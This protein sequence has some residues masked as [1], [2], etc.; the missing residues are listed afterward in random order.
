LVVY[1]APTNPSSEE[2]RME[3]RD[4]ELVDRLAL[5]ALVDEY[6]LAVDARDPDRFAGLFTP[7]GVL[8]V[9]EPDDPEPSLTYS[10]T[11]ELRTVIDLLAPFTST[12][13][14]MANHTATIDAP[15]ARTTTYCLAHHLTEAEGKDPRDTLM[16]IR[17]DDTLRKSPAGWR[18]TRRDV[19]RQWTEYHPAER[20]RLAG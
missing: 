2:P 4:D 13:H 11:D 15:A 6:A 3:I 19:L 10:G 7:D 8:A 12:V 18:F 5:R 16:L 20:A 14:V 9:I 17:Y 1:A